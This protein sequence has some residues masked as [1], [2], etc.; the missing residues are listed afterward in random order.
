MGMIV[1]MSLC[2]EEM[3]EREWIDFIRDHTADKIKEAAKRI[4]CTMCGKPFSLWDMNLGDNRYDIFVNYPSSHD[5]ERL[6][7][8]FC[9]TCFDKVLD[10]IIPMCRMNPVVDDDW[11]SHCIVRNNNKQYINE[12]LGPGGAGHISKPVRIFTDM[13]GVLCEYRPFASLDDMKKPGFFRSLRPRPE[14]VNAIKGLIEDDY[15]VYIISSIIPE[16]REQIKKE[17]NEWLDEY[18]PE[19]GSCRRFFTDTGAGKAD[20]VQNITINDVLLDDHSPNLEAWIKAGGR[21]IKVLNG[22]NGKR[23]S[24]VTGPRVKIENKEDLLDAIRNC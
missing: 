18:L 24:F 3:N 15:D 4:K 6:Q 10:T 11:L 17:K 21:A 1:N 12:G 8:N 20:V 14:M 5:G 2:T 13:D 23:G 7:F 9:T 16:C 19:I 22:I